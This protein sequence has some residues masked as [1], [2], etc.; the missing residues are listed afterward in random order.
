[1]S[2]NS[3]FSWWCNYQTGAFKTIVTSSAHHT[4]HTTWACC[5]SHTHLRGGISRGIRNLHTWSLSSENSLEQRYS[6]NTTTH[7][8]YV[9]L[10]IFNFCL[11]PFC[12]MN[13]QNIQYNETHT[14]SPV[15]GFIK[16]KEADSWLF[17]SKGRGIYF[18]LECAIFF[19][20]S[21][22]APNLY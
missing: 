7:L 6:K 16:Q 3:G 1:M 13:S 2:L 20:T 11:A 10:S 9:P 18:S 8:S 21:P 22:T 17:S 4:Q 19:V 14:C 5:Y 15:L 12:F